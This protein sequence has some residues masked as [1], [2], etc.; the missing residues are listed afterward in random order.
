VAESISVRPD[1]LRSGAARIGAQADTLAGAL[2]RLRAALGGL[3]NVCGD[4]Q[5]GHAFA[6]GYQ[7][8]VEVLESALSRMVI[9]LRE[10]ESG[11]RQMAANYEGSDAA[12]QVVGRPR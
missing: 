11:L 3:G 7:P 1:S 9:G 12:S 6:A 2:G 8:R 5:P 4:D 10:I